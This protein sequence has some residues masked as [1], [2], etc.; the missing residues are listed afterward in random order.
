M[1]DTALPA[2]NAATARQQQGL[3]LEHYLDV[4]TRKPG[5]LAGSRPLQQ[6]RRA[7]LWPKSFDEIWQALITRDGKQGGTKHRIELLKLSRQ[8]GRDHVCKAIEAALQTGCTDIAAVKHLVQAHDLNHPAC[9]VRDIGALER[10]H[11]PTPLM[12][13]YDQLLA[14]SDGR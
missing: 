11:R 14:A 10:Y 9:E 13:E 7:G 2:M 6:Q 5:A 8:F 4:L 12:N 3:D 1:T